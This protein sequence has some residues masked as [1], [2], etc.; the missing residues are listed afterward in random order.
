M[1]NW[2]TMEMGNTAGCNS[3]CV[4]RWRRRAHSQSMLS[5]HTTLTTANDLQ[6]ASS[7]TDAPLAPIATPTLPLPIS[8]RVKVSAPQ[9][10]SY[11]TRHSTAKSAQ[12]CHGSISHAA[13]KCLFQCRLSHACVVQVR[14]RGAHARGCTIG[15][16][17]A[18]RRGSGRGLIGVEERAMGGGKGHAE[19]RDCGLLLNSSGKGL[20]LSCTGR[21]RCICACRIG[22]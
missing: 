13:Q 11:P 17:T 22:R 1:P 8:S 5:R 7:F 21:P 6:R 14:E 2:V 12:I 10:L 15:A 19:P 3:H 16:G 18:A 4:S 9:R 20:S